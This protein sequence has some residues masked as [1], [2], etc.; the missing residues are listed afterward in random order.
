MQECKSKVCAMA[1]CLRK[2]SA[3]GMCSK[4]YAQWRRS[5]KGRLPERPLK[6]KSQLYIES[7]A[8]KWEG[9][10]CLKWPFQINKNKYAIVSVG[11]KSKYAHRVICLI[12]HGMPPT[13][14][15]QAWHTCGNKE[16]GCVNPKHIRWVE[17]KE[18][19]RTRKKRSERTGEAHHNSK[20]SNSDVLKIYSKKN[21]ASAAELAN[22]YKVSA[23]AIY[24]IWTRRNYRIVTEQLATISY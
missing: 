2:P 17:L 3:R 13:L 22:Q 10:D 11:R 18:S 4:H 7:V 1:G 24:M 16:G 21:I 14:S 19:M 12:K 8:L 5:I 9:D 6:S 20:L 15:S 23:S